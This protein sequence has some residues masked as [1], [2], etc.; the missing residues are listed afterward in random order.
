M[1]YMILFPL[2]LIA[3]TLYKAKIFKDG[4]F[5]E[6]A[7]SKNEAKQI[8]AFAALGIVFHHMAQRTC[9]PWL[10]PSIIVHGLD[11]FLNMGY[12]FVSVFF[13]FS[14][15]GLYLSARGK[16]NYFNRFFVRRLAPIAYF[17]V[18]SNAIFY[19]ASVHAN[20]YT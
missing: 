6:D 11:P 17:Y 4:S 9:A 13:F 15:Y 7:L 12:L 10:S 3:F 5:N 14:G 16:E 19:A 2:L 1:L 8:E 18:V 20:G